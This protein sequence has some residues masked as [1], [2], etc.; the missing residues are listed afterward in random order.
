MRAK[1]TPQEEAD[2]KVQ[3]DLKVSLAEKVLYN[4]TELGYLKKL[5][6][7]EKSVAN[8]LLIYKAIVRGEKLISTQK[9]ELRNFSCPKIAEITGVEAY[10][11]N[12]R[13][14]RRMGQKL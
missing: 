10:T 8:Q 11:V 13:Y 14:Q 5:V 9:T 6:R 12:Y 2:L 7:T 3:L 1:L 4:I